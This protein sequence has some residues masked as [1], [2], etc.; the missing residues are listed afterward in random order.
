MIRNTEKIFE[1]GKIETFDGEKYEPL[2]KDNKA[3]LTLRFG[4]KT[5]G[6]AEIEIARIVYSYFVSPIDIMDTKPLIKYV[7]GNGL[8]FRLDNI[9]LS[10]DEDVQSVVE[11]I[12]NDS[13][14]DVQNIINETNTGSLDET[15]NTA[16]EAVEVLEENV[17]NTHNQEIDEELVDKVKEVLEEENNEDTVELPAAKETTELSIEQINNIN[18]EAFKL[19]NSDFVKEIRGREEEL[20]NSLLAE[21]QEKE[22]LNLIYKTNLEEKENEIQQIKE[23]FNIVK[24][25]CENIKNENIK[26]KEEKALIAKDYY[27]I[28]KDQMQKIYRV[29]D[30]LVKMVQTLRK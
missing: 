18:T 29:F 16:E 9:E 13:T 21:Q 19:V 7:D 1:S 2:V 11:N 15:I 17:S 12:E 28:R 24:Q 25:E 10:N 26:L 6:A 30:R 23:E 20:N 22:S 3:Y 4:G 8:N 27:I 14:E 5:L